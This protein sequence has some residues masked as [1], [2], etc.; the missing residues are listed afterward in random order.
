MGQRGS[1][2]AAFPRTRRKSNAL[3][4]D[5]KICAAAAVFIPIAI[6]LAAVVMS[7]INPEKYSFSGNSIGVPAESGSTLRDNS[8][9]A[10]KNGIVLNVEGHEVTNITKEGDKFVL[11]SCEPNASTS[12]C[13]VSE[14]VSDPHKE[15]RVRV[16]GVT[17]AVKLSEAISIF[18]GQQGSQK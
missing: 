5:L 7:S 1:L 16:P 14:P 6:N 3:A 17:D 12:N 13:I 18:A 4:E 9:A 8:A 10:P 11:W 15:F 2:G